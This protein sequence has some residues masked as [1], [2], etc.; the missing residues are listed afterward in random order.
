MAKRPS[1]EKSVIKYLLFTVI[2]L[3]VTVSLLSIFVFKYTNLVSDSV[4]GVHVESLPPTLLCGA[5]RGVIILEKQGINPKDWGARCIT[6]QAFNSSSN[7]LAYL[8]CPVITPSP[9]L[10]PRPSV[11]PRVE[12]TSR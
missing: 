10:R 11:T 3:L 9:I 7:Y 12:Q 5:C 6:Q 2:V 8:I 4:L 1:Q